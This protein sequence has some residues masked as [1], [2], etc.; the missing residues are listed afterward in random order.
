[1]HAG[2]KCVE[3]SDLD[4]MLNQNMLTI[5]CH[6]SNPSLYFNPDGRQYFQ[7]ILN[8]IKECYENFENRYADWLNKL[9]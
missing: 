1:M 4:F 9:I 6:N 7:I 5:Q 8:K 3:E 2:R